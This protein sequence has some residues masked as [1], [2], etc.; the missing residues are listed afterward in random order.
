MK[1]WLVTNIE[2]L[3]PTTLSSRETINMMFVL[4][5]SQEEDGGTEKADPKHH[6]ISCAC[7]HILIETFLKYNY[8]IKFTSDVMKIPSL[9]LLILFHS[10]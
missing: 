9:G 10:A 7:H 3:I 2:T 6:Q 5:I 8:L 4:L 1:S